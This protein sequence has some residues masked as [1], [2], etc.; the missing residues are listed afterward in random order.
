MK[1][2]RFVFVLM[3]VLFAMATGCA[4]S[5]AVP[6]SNAGTPAPNGQIDIPAVSIQINAPGPNPLMGI[7]DS[8]GHIVGLLPGIWHGIIAPVTLALSFFNEDIQMYEVH[9]NGGQY[10]LGF[11]LGIMILL[12]VVSAI[13][14]SRR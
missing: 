3:T 9:N 12:G 14:A 8:Q 10:N 11:F 6:K 4:S 1:N 7:A 13:I 5:A 2:K